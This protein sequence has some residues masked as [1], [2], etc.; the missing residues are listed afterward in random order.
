MA[1]RVVRLLIATAAILAAVGLAITIEGLV[2]EQDVASRAASYVD[3]CHSA[4]GC[5]TSSGLPWSAEYSRA[6]LDL[7]V[8]PGLLVAGA[9][10]GATAL[11]L[12]LHRRA[13]SGETRTT[14]PSD[15]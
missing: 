8:G 10:L 13:N 6:L 2:L 1:G 3:P 9:G 7:V 11:A 12:A 14:P 5:P 4:Y 15:R